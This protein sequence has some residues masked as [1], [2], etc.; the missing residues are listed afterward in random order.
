MEPKKNDVPTLEGLTA[1]VISPVLARDI[2]GNAFEFNLLPE[3]LKFL[4][5]EENRPTYDIGV[6]SFSCEDK[7][8]NRYLVNVQGRS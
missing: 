8:Q 4:K 2:G 6:V 1:I 5:L 7:V 3:I